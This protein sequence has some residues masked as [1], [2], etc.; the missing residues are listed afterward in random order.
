VHQLLSYTGKDNGALPCGE[1][2]EMVKRHLHILDAVGHRHVDKLRE[3]VVKSA[4]DFISK[5]D[6]AIQTLAAAVGHPVSVE[7]QNLPTDRT[8]LNGHHNQ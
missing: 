5:V 8:K 3:K 4:E 2:A 7:S 1:I 6:E